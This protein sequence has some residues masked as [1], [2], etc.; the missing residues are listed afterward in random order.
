[1]FP[2][3]VGGLMIARR[4]ADNAVWVAFM[5]GAVDNTDFGSLWC[6]KCIPGGAWDG[7]LTRLSGT[8]QDGLYYTSGSLAVDA[9]TGDVHAIY[10]RW[11]FGFGAIL[12]VTVV[13]H[14]VTVATITN[15]GAGYPYPSFSA[16]GVT[17]TVSGNAIT[18]GAIT[19]RTPSGVGSPDARADGVYNDPITGKF[20]PT[21]VVHRVIKA[22]DS[23]STE[24][25][26]Y[27]DA[28]D[29]E[30]INNISNIKVGDGVMSVCF[31]T[32]SITS[33]GGG[34]LKV[35]RA[36]IGDAPGWEIT[37]P[38]PP[39]S[40]PDPTNAALATMETMR[41]AGLDYLLFGYTPTPGA[42][43]I[44]KYS[45]LTSTG[46]GAGWSAEVNFATAV[47]ASPLFYGNGVVCPLLPISGHR[48]IGL[49]AGTDWGEAY[50]EVDSTPP[51]PPVTGG[52][53]PQFNKRINAC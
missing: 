48:A 36:V 49:F 29:L 19:A 35:A 28:A 42:D 5:A 37:E 26:V 51:P 24:E 40:Q 23:L 6:A 1:V 52:W 45:Y 44:H 53:L 50:W 13:A 20:G 41:I 4:A 43:G 14:V 15:G 10:A 17:Y 12:Q 8:Y 34:L 22:D 9:A 31:L 47:D 46:I 11:V 38:G 2:R 7:A 30:N 3:G 27:D 25:T 33:A 32:G 18:G 21:T 16:T 39:N